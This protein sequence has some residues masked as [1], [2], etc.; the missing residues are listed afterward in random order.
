ML[1]GLG[2]YGEVY[3]DALLAAREGAGVQLVAAVDPAAQNRRRLSELRDRRVPIHESL[4]DFYDH[5]QADLAVI[6]SPIHWHCR[7]TCLALSNGSNVLCEKPAAATVQEVD[8]M[9]RAQE[10]AGK[11]VAVGYQ[12]S[13]PT[14]IQQLKR[15][16]Q[17][18][19]FG[20]PRR[21]KSLCLWPRDELYYGRNDWAGRRRAPDGTWV[22]DS[23]LNN[24][25]A[26][27]LHNMLY[28]LGDRVDAS[29]RPVELVGELYRANAIQ[30]FDTAALRVL[31]DAAVEVLFFGS[32]ATIEELDP[33]F[34]LA[35]SQA[36]V[37][38]AGGAAEIV[39]QLAD[40]ITRRY[41]SPAREPHLQK[42]WDCVAAIGQ[43]GGVACGLEAARPHVVCVNGAHDSASIVDFPRALVQVRGRSPARCVSVDGLDES[44]RA[45]YDAGVLPSESGVA[46]ARAGKRVDVRR[47]RQF[48]GGSA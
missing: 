12:W 10:K 19:L 24:A 1:V 25:M 27:D 48:P 15:D 16:I 35:F 34:Q 14:P 2:G 33:M 8:Q 28:L 36:T 6:A 42:L 21:L 3:L 41:A 39:A 38:Y 46:W 32:H 31:T 17:S 44:L 37:D 22:L 18:G 30:S 20:T 29:A 7:Q 13:Y 9:I 47:Y 23:P 40:G 11:W 43:S 4:E 45:C 5:G 26:H